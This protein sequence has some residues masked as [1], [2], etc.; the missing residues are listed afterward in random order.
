MTASHPLHYD[1]RRSALL[2]IEFQREWLDESG[3]LF[4]LVVDREP[5]DAARRNAERLIAGARTGRGLRI[6]HCGLRYTKGHP[7]L[8]MASGGLRK[9]IKD[10]GRFLGKRADFVLPFVPEGDEFN[11]LGRVG[12]SAFSGSNL[13]PYLRNNDLHTLFVAGFATHV[14]VD[15]TFRQAHDLGYEAVM[16]EDAT[17]SFTETERRHVL[18]SVVH[19]YGH[20]VTTDEMLRELQAQ[21]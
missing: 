5:F 10:G 1:F 15:S 18:D 3:S 21:A 20:A 12:V 6:L 16:V 13:D 4:H 19:H 8:G 17:A 2:F 7:E 9:L 14:C 11:V